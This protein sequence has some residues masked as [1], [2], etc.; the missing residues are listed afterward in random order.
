[1]TSRPAP[2]KPPTPAPAKLKPLSFAFPFLRKGRG[3]SEASAQFTDEH[4]IYR[5]LAEREQSGAYLVSRK[6]MWH[7]G[8][9]IT[10]TGA[11]QSLDLD[12]GLRCIADGVLIA[13]RAN[14]T[15][16]LSEIAAGGG[17]SPVQAP[18]ST[19][20]ALVRHTMEFPQGRKLTFYSLYMHL[21]SRED[22][23][24]FPKRAKP[25]YWPRQ[26][27]VTPHAQDKPSPGRNGQTV[28]PSQQGLRVRK[29]HPRG[30][31]IGILPQG[32]SV[33]IGKQEKG[34][35][36]VTE[37]HEAVL[38]PP[39]AGG[40]VEPSGAV[41]GWVYLGRENGGPLV[42]EVYPDSM[43]DR[44]IV[45]AN[46]T[47]T[48][49]NPQ[50]DG[51]IPVKAGDLMGHLGRYDSLNQN[52]SGTRM[53][54]IEVFCDDSI[55]S[56]LE[57]GR[58]WVNEHGPHKE[59]W[60]T[61]GL[62]SEPTILRIAPGT[63]L[64]QRT[65]GNKFVPGA[66]PQSRKTDAVQVY[67]LAEL[68]RDPKRRV[69]EPHPNPN[70][71]YPVN[72]WHVDGV[73]AQGQP[74]EGWVCD[75]NHAGGR[76]TRE[77]AQKWIDFECLADV[78]DPAHTIFATTQAWV[79][80]ASGAKVAD[81]ASRSKL[82]PLMLKVY[83]ALFTKG[84]GKRAADELC[85]LAQTKRGGYPWLMQA[86]SRL[87]VRHESE[88]ANPSK[89]KQL[90]AE[91]EKQ[92]GPKPQHEE[93]QK[94]IDQLAWW[95]EVK[96]G[97]PGFPGPD[98]FHIHPV[99]LV[100]NF[101]QELGIITLEMLAAVDPNGSE[102]YHRQILPSL[103]KYAK[104]YQVT[105][106]R[107]IAHFLSQIAVESGFKNVEEGLSYSAKR[108]KQI[109]GCNAPPKGEKAYNEMSGEIVC[110]FGRKREKLWTE[111]SKYEYNPKNLASYV[112]ADRYKNGNEE[113]GDGYKYRG[114]GLIQTT[115][116]SNYMVLTE[117][118]NRRFPDDQR[119]FVEDPDLV[120]SDLEYGVESAFVF[121]A[122]T[123]NVNEVADSEDVRAV[124]KAVNGG[125]IGYSERLAAYNSVAPILGLP[126]EV[127]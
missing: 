56:F 42:E 78:H 31:T 27:K 44:V 99:A 35:G 60:V 53:A 112:Y 86:A 46:Q 4:E 30:E 88:W 34:W 102:S 83:D 32:T 19:G 82:S 2:K 87:I 51:G 72:W 9:H 117:E 21:M 24:N 18:Y 15:Y 10:E 122:V 5:L 103:N 28:D 84:D 90:I 114:R 121:W 69:P 124:S 7:G 66:E 74:I 80:Y 95:D 119:D 58:A 26:W 68:A 20:F 6:G 36:Q 115:F 91:L 63:V 43:F 22:Y 48:T 64:Y 3:K 96:A 11:G 45:T 65:E 125:T 23:A 39:E 94:R 47:C 123:K 25:S 59:D 49:G 55:Q 120:L 111:K 57:Q 41:G 13:F 116:K 38:Y 52:T 17:G 1:M 70:P 77:F 100:G 67:S 33:S 50:G 62:P 93:E 76:V 8:V 104:G 89:W 107:R 97:V 127:A 113:S 85:T 101:S 109:F 92:T 37:L 12:A 71:G 29:S 105:T 14:K 98:V 106:P 61:L 110:N 73:N 81:V 40:Y 75:F 79:E 54:H 16:P 108:M 126:K 118:H